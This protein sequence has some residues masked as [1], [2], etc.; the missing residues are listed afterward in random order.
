MLVG[1]LWDTFGSIDGK[2][3]RTIRTLVTRPGAL[4][5]EYVRG[6]RVAYLSP[7][8]TYLTVAG[9]YFALYATSPN[10]GLS[11]VR[12]LTR[13]PARARADS[14]VL[15]DAQR[16]ARTHH[17]PAA[18]L[19]LGTARTVNDPVA[20]VRATTTALPRVMFVMVPFCALLVWRAYNRRG[21]RYPAHLYF[22]LHVIAFYFAGCVVLHAAAAYGSERL[23]P[24][25]SKVLSLAT[26][27]Y[28]ALAMQ[29]MYG[30]R[31]LATA[32]RVLFV[33]GPLVVVFGA[34]VMLTAAVSL[35]MR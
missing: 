16:Y 19:A 2:V 11:E 24:V 5:V 10:V 14:V 12:T 25:G 33:L 35:G 13:T 7:L 22:A 23:Y 15:A 29:R 30:G 27:A 8:K 4:T 32:A 9:A 17:G 20:A 18:T 1:E 26:I 28:F 21:L 34:A 6:R 31:K 3:V